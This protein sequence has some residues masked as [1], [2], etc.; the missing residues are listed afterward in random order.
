MPISVMSILATAPMTA[1][2][3]QEV[4]RAEIE[5]YSLDLIMQILRT[6]NVDQFEVP[7]KCNLKRILLTANIMPYLNRTEYGS[8]ILNLEGFDEF[9]ASA[10]EKCELQKHVHG[11]I[12]SICQP[13]HET[14]H[15]RLSTFPDLFENP[16]K[17]EE[18]LKEMEQQ[19]LKVMI[20]LVEAKHKKC[21]L[22]KRCA[23]MRV[24]SHQLVGPSELLL[25]VKS[26][27]SKMK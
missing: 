17:D 15:N 24:G 2:E 10:E 1:V 14:I 19:R 7:D 5:F 26:D 12:V 11:R 13:I 3:E 18:L 22:L 21:V 9:T 16:C 25:D 4:R 6:A 27:L 20:G 23:E 8:T